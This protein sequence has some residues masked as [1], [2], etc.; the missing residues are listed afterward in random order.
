MD[1]NIIKRDISDE[2]I[3]YIGSD[4]I[5]VL[6]GARQVGKSHIMFYLE[7]FIKSQKKETYFFDLEDS[8]LVDVLNRGAEETILFLQ[9]EGVELEKIKSN[10][11]KIYVFID[12]IQYLENPSPLMKL[13]GDHHKYIQLIVSGS[14]SFD[15]KSKFTDSL[16][17]RT[18]EFEIFSLSF[19]EFLRFRNFNYDAKRKLGAYHLEKIKE[20]YNEYVFFGAYPKIVLEKS[21]AKKEKY[22]NQIIDTYIKK[23]IRDLAKIRDIK[24]FN[25]M[26][27][28]LAAQSGQLLNVSKLAKTCSLAQ[29]TVEKYLFILE[30]TFIIKL[31]TPY[32]TSPKVEVV[33]APKIFFYD[34]GIVQMLWLRKFSQNFV[35]NIFETS[36]FAELVKKYGKDKI[37][38]W[39]NRNQNE[40]DF[41]LLSG[42]KP[43]PIE[44]KMNFGNFRASSLSHFLERYKINEYRIV[45]L[46]G[47]TRGEFYVYPW[48]I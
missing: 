1:K 16:V 11:E 46:E 7:N 39:R 48:E 12:E 25:D 4:N 5:I 8:R 17:G 23:D 9:N 21:V 13:L 41:I 22:L 29:Q 33:K 2:I 43:L 20:M 3:K 45:G 19:S 38:Y 40:I 15:I 32:S 26:L 10:G 44:V 47:E 35:G 30:N 36:I 24:K 28:V 14:S 42:E 37:Y 27:K 34:T 18:V 31:V 6:H